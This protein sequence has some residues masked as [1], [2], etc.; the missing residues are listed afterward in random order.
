[1][2]RD[3]GAARRARPGWWTS[4]FVT[5]PVATCR[6]ISAIRGGLCWKAPRPNSGSERSYGVSRWGSR[7]R[8]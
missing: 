2:L 8:A 4:R 7:R 5:G 1:M 3:A 6:A